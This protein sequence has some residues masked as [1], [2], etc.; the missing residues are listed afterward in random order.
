MHRSLKDPTN[1]VLFL[2]TS[3]LNNASFSYDAMFYDASFFKRPIAN[4]VPFLKTS[5][6]NKTS[7]TKR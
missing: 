4:D 5:K 6:L 7:K 2:K 3:K 1:D